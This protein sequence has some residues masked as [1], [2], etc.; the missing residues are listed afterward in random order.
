MQPVYAYIKV[1]T[2][3]QAI[4]GYSQRSQLER[5]KN[6]C[7]YNNIIIT[8]VIFEDYSAKTFNRPE[9][10]R[11]ITKLKFVKNQP[12][13]I[14]FTYWDRFSRNITDAY[15]MLE[16]LKIK[17][18]SIQAIEQPIDFSIP[19]SKIMLAI[20]LATSEV[21]ND[22]R[23]RNVSLGMQKA[24]LEGR[25][26][27]KAPIGYRNKVTA[28][29]HKYIAPHGPEAIIIRDVFKIIVQE[30]NLPLSDVYKQAVSKGLKCSL[31]TFYEMLRNPVY[32]GR[33]R[34]PNKDDAETKT[35]KGN[36]DGVISLLLFE[37]V[38]LK[39]KKP[40]HLNSII[41]KSINENLVLRGIFECPNCG[42][43]LTGSGSKGRRKKYYYYHCTK[44]CPYRLSA[45]LLNINFLKFLKNL[46]V[47]DVFRESVRKISN[48]INT[49]EQ[50]TYNYKKSEIARAVE[51]VVNRNLNAQQLFTRG[52]IDYDDYN[53]IK[54]NCRTS[55]ENYTEQ[56]QTEAI[57]L[58][59]KKQTDKH[60]DLIINNLA[61]LYESADIITKQKIIRL[62]F[63]EK[64]I[65]VS[66]QIEELLSDQ[67]KFILGISEFKQN[68]QAYN[69]K[70]NDFIKEL[71]F[72]RRDFNFTELN[73]SIS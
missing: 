10:K 46:N 48:D 72:L 62:F 21:E 12:S 31:T 65:L 40:K 18:V 73:E 4:K 3:E 70:I 38:Q 7:E 8:E 64:V 1:S 51:K 41:R 2:D 60:C 24:R 59:S 56:L 54:N 49:N 33:I 6:Y 53:L 17:N 14:L 28:D 44:G 66:N 15:S 27:G 42:K 34:I 37:Q 9:W 36:H 55:L 5:I 16:Q 43:T 57:K 23:S 26:I 47:D 45:A 11:L 30:K 13:L 52:E 39:L 50:E 22:K 58:I 68:D 35:I 61:D 71:I 19:E 67:I 32:C 69:Q 29:G 20:Y 25:Y 63:P